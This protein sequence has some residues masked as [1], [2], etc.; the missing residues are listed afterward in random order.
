MLCT[1]ILSFDFLLK[2]IFFLRKL[3][4]NFEITLQITAQRVS[5]YL[6]SQ[7]VFTKP[8]EMGRERII[9]SI[10]E[11]RKQMEK[12]K[13]LSPEPRC[14]VFWPR[15][16]SPTDCHRGF[17]RRHCWRVY[18]DMTCASVISQRSFVL[19]SNLTYKPW[20]F[21]WS[22]CINVFCLRASPSFFICGL[23]KFLI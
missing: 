19:V 17:G 20:V 8:R 9:N 7:F 18:G 13:M 10:S 5:N 2:S 11:I 6:L 4:L 16:S 23:K 1:I 14:F 3:S 22:M 21:Y 15:M 12:V